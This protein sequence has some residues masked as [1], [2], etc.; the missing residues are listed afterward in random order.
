MTTKGL[1][2]TDC[3]MVQLRKIK[4]YNS[5]STLLHNKVNQI[6]FIIKKCLF[7]NETVT[8]V[9]TNETV[10]VVITNVR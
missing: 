7:Y 10:T 2:D 9:I 5:H 8:V 3:K 6:I 1:F 4:Q